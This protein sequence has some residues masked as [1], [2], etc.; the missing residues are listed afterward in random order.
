MVSAPEVPAAEVGVVRDLVR[1]EMC[2]AYPLDPPL[3]VDIGDIRLKSLGLTRLF[4][5]LVAQECAGFGLALRALDSGRLGIAACAVGL[6]Q[7][8]L[9]YAGYSE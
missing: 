6:A 1:E 7:A 5:T 4:R 3:A 2:R 8:A 9:D